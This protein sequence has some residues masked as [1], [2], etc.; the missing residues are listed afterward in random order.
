MIIDGKELLDALQ[1]KIKN[2]YPDEDLNR[3][4]NVLSY[5]DIYNTIMELTKLN[6]LKS[7]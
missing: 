1:Q 6:E 5:A 7:R 4:Q 2:T 3:F